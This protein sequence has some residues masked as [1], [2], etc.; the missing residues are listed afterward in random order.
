MST[1]SLVGTILLVDIP[2]LANTAAAG[3]NCHLLG[4]PLVDITLHKGPD[5]G[6]TLV[7]FAYDSWVLVCFYLIQVVYSLDDPSPPFI[8]H[9]KGS[10]RIPSTTEQTPN[11]RNF[12]S[13]RVVGQASKLH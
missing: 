13:F 6:Q 7:A 12:I 8:L 11:G 5:R 2:H 9:Y 1:Q 3:G 4:Y 10:T